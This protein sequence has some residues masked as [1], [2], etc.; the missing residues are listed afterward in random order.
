MTGKAI[1]FLFDFGSPNAYLVHRVIPQIESRQPVV[2]EYVPVL[3]GGIFK[4]TNNQ[5][6]ATAFAHIPAKLAYDRLEIDRFCARHGI[7]DYRM[8]PHFPVNTLTLMRGA[9][10]A[11]HLGL[12][13]PYVETVYHAMWRD[14]LKM[15]DP[16]VF[17]RALDAAGLPAG[18]I[19]A[20]SQAPEVKG[21]LIANTD[22]AVARGAFGAPTFFVDDAIYFG[23]DRL[24]EAV[25][26]ALA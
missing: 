10:A 13:T 18:E 12:F 3:L 2:F 5:S 19:A 1:A 4:A 21:G 7:A 16:E 11:Q 24:D 23:K 15:D 8:N 22:R 26:A 25:R 17:A 14:G 20:R 9:I 6:P